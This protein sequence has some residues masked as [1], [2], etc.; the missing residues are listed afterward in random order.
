M[1]IPLSVSKRRGYSMPLRL[2]TTDS[3]GEGKAGAKGFIVV[4]V[5]SGL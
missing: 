2:A 4:L 1:E 5:S 3:G